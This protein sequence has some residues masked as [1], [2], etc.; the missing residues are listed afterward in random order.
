MNKK[1]LI[2][3]MDGT[4]LDSMSMWNK[5]FENIICYKEKI[6]SSKKIKIQKG[7]TIEYSVN[8]LYEHMGENLDKEKL[9]G[10]IDDYLLNFYNNKNLK[11][12]NVE[13]VISKLKDEGYELYIATATDIKYVMLALKKNNL[14]QYFTKVYTPD[15]LMVQKHEKGYFEKILKDLD[16]DSSDAIFFDDVLYAVKLSKSVNIKTVG[17]YDKNSSGMEEMKKICDYFIYDFDEINMEWL[18]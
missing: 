4:L 6:K 7:T 9:A 15:T 5:L 13:K 16:I 8:Y 18:K 11:K 10:F 3:D 17:V 2:F 1:K 12:K 14:I